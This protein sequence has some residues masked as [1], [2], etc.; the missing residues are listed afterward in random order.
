MSGK[1]S[2]IYTPDSTAAEYRFQGN[3]PKIQNA[4]NYK[5]QV[6]TGIHGLPFDQQNDDRYWQ[7]KQILPNILRPL[8]TGIKNAAIINEGVYNINPIAGTNNFG[9]RSISLAS[10]LNPTNYSL[11]NSSDIEDRLRA[12]AVPAN[13]PLSAQYAQKLAP[14]AQMDPNNVEGDAMLNTFRSE[15]SI[16]RNA[17][18]QV[19]DENL[20]TTES[21]DEPGSFYQGESSI[22]GKLRAN[23]NHATR[24][25]RGADTTDI[26]RNFLTRNAKEA[27]RR[28]AALESGQVYDASNRKEDLAAQAGME[29]KALDIGN[30][31]TPFESAISLNQPVLIAGDDK[32]FTD[33]NSPNASDV[34][35]QQSHLNNQNAATRGDELRDDFLTEDDVIENSLAYGMIRNFSP[36]SS[37]TKIRGINEAKS[38]TRAFQ[39]F[40][41]MYNSNNVVM[42]QL[43]IHNKGKNSTE[44]NEILIYYSSLSDQDIYDQ[45]SEVMERYDLINTNVNL[46]GNAIEDFSSQLIQNKGSSDNLRSIEELDQD[47]KNNIDTLHRNIREANMQA[48]R[49]IDTNISMM[50]NNAFRKLNKSL[51][52]KNNEYPSDSLLRVYQNRDQYANEPDYAR[53]DDPLLLTYGETYV[54]KEGGGGQAPVE[55]EFSKNS[56]STNKMLAGTISNE[57]FTNAFT[58]QGPT[59]LLSQSNNKANKEIKLEKTIEEMKELR[60]YSNQAK[61][62]GGIVRMKFETEKEQKKQKRIELKQLIA[63]T[64]VFITNSKDDEGEKMVKSYID[65]IYDSVVKCTEV[66]C[67][68]SQIEA[69]VK[70]ALKHTS[71]YVHFI[72]VSRDTGMLTAQAKIGSDFRMFSKKRGSAA[73]EMITTPMQKKSTSEKERLS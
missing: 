29:I 16:Q 32:I 60:N 70:S 4:Y 43:A 72:L 38:P 52:D 31:K 66:G 48:I 5:K 41:N 54:P 71:I 27:V 10:G 56:L 8:G 44:L 37:P 50:F 51:L 42:R 13:N 19:Y 61:T 7:T 36:P 73:F 26:M 57:Q 47:H 9:G 18:S 64:Q 53:I 63:R 1:K 3:Q 28:G 20:T 62:G 17:K 25:I 24:V 34:M 15:E 58:P 35:Q 68:S 11:V 59:D 49:S 23:L 55:E 22:Y 12:N 21:P 69:A 2:E 6:I 30:T 14:D 65:D 46:V 45:A 39:A 40:E 33:S 67:S